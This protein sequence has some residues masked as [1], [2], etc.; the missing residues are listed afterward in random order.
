MSTALVAPRMTVEEF[1][2]RPEREDGMREELIDG[3]IIVSPN[4]KKLHTEVSSNVYDLLLPLKQQGFA[5]LGETACRLTEHALPNT[6]ASVVQ[7]E[8]WK[9]V[10]PDDFLR[11]SPALAIE[12]YSPKNTKPKLL[13]KVE[14]Y[15][16]H[17]AEQCWV[18][19]PKQRKVVIYFPDGTSE[20]KRLGDSLSFYDCAFA[21]ADLFEPR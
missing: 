12:V 20:E 3:E 9:A 7:R 15:L 2:Q 19:Y 21:V 16:E 10:P 14:L 13:R 5:V 18:I 11:E 17:G 4:A 8:R 6:D 1:L